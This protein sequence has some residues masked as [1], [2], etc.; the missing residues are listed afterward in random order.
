MRFTPT[1]TSTTAHAHSPV[2]HTTSMNSCTSIM[3]KGCVAVAVLVV[4]LVAFVVCVYAASACIALRRWCRRRD[5]WH[6]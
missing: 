5:Y 4:G 1:H 6:L 3:G 2:M